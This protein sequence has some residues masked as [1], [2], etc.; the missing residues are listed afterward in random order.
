MKKL[1]LAIIT[2]LLVFQTVLSPLSVFAEEGESSLPPSVETGTDGTTSDSAGTGDTDLPVPTPGE[3]GEAGGADSSSDP[4]EILTGDTESGDV[5]EG[6]ET[7]DED[8]IISDNEEKATTLQVDPLVIVPTQFSISNLDIRQGNDAATA[9][10]IVGSPIIWSNTNKFFVY[11]DWQLKETTGL[12][13]GDSVE[14]QLPTQFATG[15]TSGNL[16][17]G[18]TS[19][20]TYVVDNTN[21]VKF[22]FN[23]NAVDDVASGDLN[24]T[25][26]LQRDF[27]SSQFEANK[28]ET[29]V[30][31]YEGV[32]QDSKTV[33]FNP[34]VTTPSKKGQAYRDAVLDHRNANKILWTIDIN[35]QGET[36]SD[37]I[38]KDTPI[39]GLVIDKTTVKVAPLILNMDGSV[40][41]VGIETPVDSVNITDTSDGF[42]IALGQIN[43]AVRVTYETTIDRNVLTGTSPSVNNEAQLFDDSTPKTSI[44]NSNNISLQYAEPL[45]KEFVANSYDSITQTVKWR[46]DYNLDQV[47]G[48]DGVLIDELT[49]Q[50][51]Q[52]VAGSAKYY[53][54]DV[55][56]NLTYVPINSTATSIEPTIDPSNV[57]KLKFNLPAGK[58]AY[59]IEYETKL[60][61]RIDSLNEVQVSNKVIAAGTEKT[62]NKKL[63]Q[64]VFHKSGSTS[65]DYNNKLLSWM[66]KVN[67]DQQPMENVVV[68][69]NFQQNVGLSL[70]GDGFKNLTAL[71][72]V[73]VE[74]KQ[75]DDSYR[76]I[77]VGDAN[78]STTKGFKLTFPSIITTE[79]VIE[80]KTHFQPDSVPSD[81]I[82]KNS[83]SISWGPNGNEYGF[84]KNAT[85]TVDSY[86]SGN[87]NK[88]VEYDRSTKQF[89]WTVD[90]NYNLDHLT[91]AVLTDTF[92]SGQKLV[93]GS[94][95]VYKLTLNNTTN[96]V[97]PVL[98]A[99]SGYAFSDVTPTS[100]NLN[101]GTLD[102]EA[103]RII[104]KTTLKD[105]KV[106]GT[107]SNEAILNATKNGTMQK[108]FDKDVPFT[109][110]NSGEVLSK[111][112][113]QNT[114]S[115]DLADWTVMLNESRSKLTTTAN[116]VELTDIL[117]GDQMLL[118]DTFALEEQY[119]DVGSIS[120]KYRTLLKATIEEG[121]EYA[122]FS[123]GSEVARI[124]VGVDITGKTKFTLL[125]LQD[126][127]NQY[128]LT[129]QTFIEA[130]QGAT[131]GN[132]ASFAGEFKS[133]LAKTTSNKTEIQ[134]VASGA[135][136][137]GRDK[138][139][140]K[141]VD[142]TN[143]ST[144][145]EGAVF[146]LY[147]STGT[148]L[149]ESNLTTGADGTI[150]TS[151]VYNYKTYKLE[152]VKAPLGYQ[153]ISGKIDVIFDATTG[154]GIIK[155]TKINAGFSCP[156]FELTVNNLPTEL[157]GKV[158]TLKKDGTGPD[159]NLGNLDVDGK[160][161]SS[162]S[163]AGGTYSVYVDGQ[164]MTEMITV[165][166]NCEAAITF[167]IG[168]PVFML[169]INNLPTDLVGK[170]VTVK[171]D[172]TGPIINLGNLDS[173]GKVK[174]PTLTNGTYTVYV[175]G[176]IV[177]ETIT[178][179]NKCEAVIDYVAGCPIFTLTINNL[180]TELVGKSVT[181]K[182]DGTGTT[183]NL[184]NIDATGKVTVPTPLVSGTYTVFVDGQ[185]MAETI[186]VGQ[187]C[188]ATITFIKG[189]PV[190]TLTIDN[191]SNDDVGKKVKL[192]SENNV[193]EIELG[194]INNS[195]AVTF[196]I[197]K[198]PGGTYKV[199]IDNDE[200]FGKVIVNDDTN[201][202]GTVKVIK[203]C[204]QFTLTVNQF[205]GVSHVGA[206][207]A[208]VIKTTTGSYVT[209][210]VTDANGQ[211][212]FQDKSL[213][214]E[215][216]TY[217]VYNR[218][219]GKLGNIHVTY[220]EGKCA[221][222]VE[223]TEN[224]CP[225]FTLTIQDVY[226]NPREG[227]AFTI[228]DK[229]GMI[230]ATST[231]GAS[232][233]V[234]IPYTVEPGTYYVYEGS[235]LISSI[236]VNDCEA[237][238]KPVYTGGGGGGGSTP[239]PE[240]PVDPS[241]PTPDPE[242]PV[243]PNK[244]T[245]D[246]EKPVD[247]NKPTPDP[248]KPVDP[249]KPT[250]DPENPVD[251]NK[252]TPDP[253]NPS[254][255]PDEPGNP[256]N[257]STDS[258]DPTTPGKPDTSKP[259]V[260]DVI[261][262]GKNLPPYNPSTANKDTLDAYKD[263]L[264]KY[265]NLSKEDQANVAKTLDINKI[266]EDAQR[267]EAQ[268]KAQGKLP[269][270]DGANQTALTLTG[271][272]LVLGALFFLRRREA[273]MK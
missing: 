78:E 151:K 106:T 193:T 239:D 100:F 131:I 242:K 70:K 56:S 90:V 215:G 259:S 39:P 229:N 152:E 147:N 104:Y 217:D 112:G 237:I 66:L 114:P 16:L 43:G 74:F 51:H 65:V 227:V 157:A 129:Y 118:T 258:K 130:A 164:L 197:N 59:R 93:A 250:P 87:G 110:T 194:T 226:G 96:G 168:C 211:I 64:N 220:E 137:V 249:N 271:V 141:K 243:D 216:T 214:V 102:K 246:P 92:S 125:F 267:L 97:T 144:V 273:E 71:S 187:D 188:E 117:Q 212:I 268:L 173:N 244:P 181:V 182:K 148:V 160:V 158:V 251:P 235:S 103:Y 228:K 253:E 94:L 169:T 24:G 231:T 120:D 186:T 233:K 265:N 252:P 202:A 119:Y 61:N 19:Y 98:P 3:T 222:S 230:I 7:T 201:C 232:G 25:F 41:S 262:Q 77:T 95:E 67:S 82:Y 196:T 155:N 245:P 184:G 18:G 140:I 116:E 101:L 32:L 161:T 50:N 247:P 47:A 63:S 72:G 191:A 223:V 162:T 270:T 126:I 257:P 23:Q 31:S 256:E 29:L 167:A 36:L 42:D 123:A 178:V 154:I 209:E 132:E 55:Q 34:S 53:E 207:V 143:A 142:S 261:D 15:V 171:K 135:T 138:L 81:L 218:L 26:N 153:K 272:M 89:T 241:K 60:D 179:D 54:L 149:L 109:P 255:N 163:I 177:I 84:D 83:A 172:G 76:E 108:V 107:Y 189:C 9:V 183:I 2:L 146:N 68:V 210:G 221:D 30:I 208:V 225:I 127:E 57:Y 121:K 134:W 264:D 156:N 198:V 10:S 195:G 200:L 240:K 105:E 238:A 46:I 145:L 45:K 37:A 263:F 124:K 224:A 49:S 180:P 21:K 213:L 113:K 192:V 254:T 52:Y 219:G 17:L 91:N 35:H 5:T 11:L 136:V 185:A 133:E 175:D 6:E 165:D 8:K 14:F 28:P 128:K 260:Q 205:G 4:T 111:T 27:D 266:K 159:I 69:D 236:V 174:A 122:F 13:V 199:F 33:I 75:D 203:A 176:Q 40:K 204:P 190:F 44:I 73:K 269:Q 170:A 1:N 99:L 115:S 150:Q 20:G 58:K 139:T 80:Y 48:R 206:G 88:M 79:Q 38:L 22:T 234:T 166:G 86:T 62:D 248:E 12:V 85:N